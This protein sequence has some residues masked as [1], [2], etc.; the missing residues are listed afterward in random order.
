VTD[1][2]AQFGELVSLLARAAPQRLDVLR[3][4]FPG[5]AVQ[6]KPGAVLGQSA[7]D[8]GCAIAREALAQYGPAADK[9]RPKIRNRLVW[10]WRFDFAAKFAAACGSGGAVGVLASGAAV[11]K[12]MLASAIALIGSFC[13][14]LVSY[15]QRDQ[16]A[17]SVSDSYNKLIA[18]LVQVDDLQRKLN[19][20]CGKG[21]SPELREALSQANDTAKS[22]NELVLRF[23]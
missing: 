8:V 10:S 22:L 6:F 17:G 21:D 1:N 18:A 5:H 14:L 20:L 23:S 11:D 16:S 15:L 4:N 3:S 9:L 13:G 12:A 7:P 19:A 2:P